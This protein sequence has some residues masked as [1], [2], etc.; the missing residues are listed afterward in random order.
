MNLR[1][2][3][4][5]GVLASAA[6]GGCGDDGDSD[7]VRVAA[8]ASFT[9]VV[10]GLAGVLADDLAVEADLGGSATLVRQILDGA[11]A[12]VFVSADEET[13]DRLVDAGGAVGTP[14]TVATNVLVLVVPAGNEADVTG[15]GDLAR[16]ELAIGRCADDVPCGRLAL[17]ELDDAGIEDVADTEE[18]D[19]RSL[20]AKV[21]LGELDAALVYRT[22]ALAAGDDLTVVP[23]DRLD[24]STRYQAVTVAGGD[25][26]AAR[27][28]LAALRGV[29]GTTLLT[30]LGFGTP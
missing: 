10:E 7:R 20:L 2:I 18:P 12:D 5:A 23:D 11:P 15:L 4:L 29:P 13:M 17:S 16:P 30:A 6:A 27:R 1:V 24:M 14:V 8:A 28:F 19:V 25:Q 3:A 21:V 22:D 26:A 9:D